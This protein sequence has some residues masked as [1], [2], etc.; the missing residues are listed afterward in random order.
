[1]GF[2]LANLT[3]WI[4]HR[5]RKLI[6]Y[7]I[8]RLGVIE[9]TLTLLQTRSYVM[10]FWIPCDTGLLHSNSKS[11]QVLLPPERNIGKCKH[12][13]VIHHLLCWFRL[14]YSAIA[15]KLLC[16]PCQ[17]STCPVRIGQNGQCLSNRYTKPV[18]L[19][20]EK[21]IEQCSNRLPCRTNKLIRDH[22]MFALLLMKSHLIIFMNTCRQCRQSRDN[23]STRPL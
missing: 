11:L 1:M 10:H 21:P 19:R 23:F 4:G 3:A 14:G 15:T 5:N 13:R 8:M 9:I 22:A 18:G 16:P 7:D 17:I 6:D 12:Y 2:T 20:A